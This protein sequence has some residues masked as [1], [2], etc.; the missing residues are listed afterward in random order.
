MYTNNREHRRP[1]NIGKMLA[2][3]QNIET[4]ISVD[5]A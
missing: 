1:V 4:K 3:M 2:S 5:L